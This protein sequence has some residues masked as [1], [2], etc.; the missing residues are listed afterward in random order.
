M[1]K[2]DTRRYSDRREYL[3]AAVQR[4]RKLIR[5]MAIEYKG[6]RC[7]ICGYDRCPDALEFHHQDPSQKNFGISVKGYARS[8]IKVRQEIEKCILICANCHRELHAKSQLSIE[9]WIEK[10]G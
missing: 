3:I 7:Q 6:G 4:R 10:A 5:Q 8:W 1:A 9:R 2:R